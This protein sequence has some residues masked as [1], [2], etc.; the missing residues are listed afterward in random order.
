MRFV[1]PALDHNPGLR[2]LMIAATAA[3]L[4]ACGGGGGG[5]GNPPPP[6]HTAPSAN[7]G[8]DQTVEQNGAVTLT[9]TGTDAD[10][11]GLTYSWT[12]I[13]G[14]GVTINNGNQATASFTAPS[15][16]AVV[17]LTFRLTVSDGSLNDTD[18][19]V[20]SVFPDTSA[21]VVAGSVSY[22]FVPGSSGGLRYD[23]TEE[24]PVRGAT[25]QVIQASNSAVLA[26][27]VQLIVEGMF[28]LF[29]VEQGRRA[30]AG[31]L[32]QVVH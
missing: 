20:I 18:D 24:R 17:T 27:H 10:G 31:S 4:S 15:T 26:Q 32:E 6:V 8:A 19:I 25:I 1:P 22:E 11:D 30:F 29:N 3:V 14:P 5:G 28:L 16:S 21:P 23:E 2:R 7:A 9:G 13:S 12:Q